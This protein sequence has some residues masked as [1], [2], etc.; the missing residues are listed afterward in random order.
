[1]TNKKRKESR[2]A[3]IKDA[4]KWIRTGF[5]RPEEGHVIDVSVLDVPDKK[6]ELQPILKNFFKKKTK[7]ASSFK[8]CSVCARGALL[9]STVARSNDYC[10]NL[11]LVVSK[12]G[13]YN[14]TKKSK[15]KSTI[16][17]RLEQI[18]DGEQLALIECAFEKGM[19]AEVLSDEQYGKARDFGYQYPYSDN[20]RL[21]AIFKNI[22]K[23]DG[24]FKP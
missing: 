7:D 20:D 3:V 14:H 9:L 21:L 5:L 10:V 4:I 15:A 1:M 11:D 17:R 2:I 12:T 6:V 23:N 19:N 13:G 16:D 18:F 8:S 22:L 24:T